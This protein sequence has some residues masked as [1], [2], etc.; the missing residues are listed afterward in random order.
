MDLKEEAFDYQIKKEELL[1]EQLFLQQYTQE[2]EESEYGQS[3]S[4]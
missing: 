3:V 2:E 4:K 1:K